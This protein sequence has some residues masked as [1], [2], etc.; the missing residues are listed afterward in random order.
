MLFWLAL[1]FYF[2][3]FHAMR[4]QHRGWFDTIIWPYHVGYWFVMDFLR[5]KNLI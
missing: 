4:N 1:M 2:G 5:G 3:G